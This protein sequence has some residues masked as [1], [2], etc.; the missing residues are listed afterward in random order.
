MI[1]A[2][3]EEDFVK[4]SFFIIYLRCSGQE[5]VSYYADIII[6]LRPVLIT[7][8]KMSQGIK[9]IHK[10]ADHFSQHLL[11]RLCPAD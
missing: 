6:T 7:T 8:A 11:H 2:D 9:H 4:H 3:V 5:I 10:E 1:K